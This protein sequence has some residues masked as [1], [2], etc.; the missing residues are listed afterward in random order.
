MVLRYFGAAHRKVG[1]DRKVQTQSR[2]RMTRI[3]T[4]PRASALSAFYF[5]PSAFIR[6]HLRLISVSL[7]DRAGKIKGD[8]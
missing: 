4:Y 6:V 3:Y 5:I 1:K 7:S 2:T 8:I